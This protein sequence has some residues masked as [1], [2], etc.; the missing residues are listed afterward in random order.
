V[1]EKSLLTHG[2]EK[3]G[4]PPYKKKRKR[5]EKNEKECFGINYKRNRVSKQSME[6]E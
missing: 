1:Q 3:N 5:E 4:T 2:V 6:S